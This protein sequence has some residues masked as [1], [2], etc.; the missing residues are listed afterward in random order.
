[1]NIHFYKYQGTGNDFILIDNRERSLQLTTAQVA[2][3]CDRRFGIGADGLMLLEDTP[4]YDFAMTYYNSDG[5][6]STMCGNGGRCITAFARQLG[7][8]GNSAF[9]KAI[10]GA[11]HAHFTA[12]GIVA[13]EMNNVAEI[14]HFDGYSI[15]NTGSP[16]YVLW[17]EHVANMDVFSLG[18]AIR[19]Q[20]DFM[21]KGIN[22]NF[23]E[24]KN[25]D[26]IYVRTYERGVEAETYSCGT[27]VTA[28][29]IA[30]TGGQTGDF[31]TAITTPGGALRVSF[32]KDSPSTAQN[33][34]L[35]G[36]AAFVYD[37]TIKIDG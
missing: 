23:A 7:L 10:D 26:H 30:A 22:V 11:H 13:L 27:G 14:V 21:P 36:P 29:A 5:N 17:S 2:F 24:R 25:K 3:L 32:R 12:T 20:P 19:N 15:L 1:M 18:R 34:V 8:I 6:E 33:V 9:F 35:T 16:H 31:D 28:C 4:G 37:G